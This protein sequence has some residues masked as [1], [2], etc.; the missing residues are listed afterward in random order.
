[1]IIHHTRITI[2]WSWMCGRRAAPGSL[3]PEEQA[4]ES[5]HEDVGRCGQR[6]L[7]DQRRRRQGGRGVQPQPGQQLEWHREQQRMR[8][9]AQSGGPLPGEVAVPAP[10]RRL[11][12]CRTGQANLPG[13]RWAS[14]RGEGGSSERSP[15]NEP[16]RDLQAL[17][18]LVR[19]ESCLDG[20]RIG[21]PVDAAKQVEKSHAAL[22]LLPDRCEHGLKTH[23][24]GSSDGTLHKPWWLASGSS[25]GTLSLSAVP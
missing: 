15:E 24:S 7:Q 8:V 9:A 25:V 22:I 6:A 13:R 1:M 10:V 16:V 21:N 19:A 14:T 23:V 20:K 4:R 12:C 5:E 18:I 17:P 2:T 11:R 3:S